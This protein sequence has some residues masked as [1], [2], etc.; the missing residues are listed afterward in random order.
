MKDCDFCYEKERFPTL[1]QENE[2]L[3]QQ[4]KNEKQLNAE[5]KK[6]LVAVEYDSNDL[7]KKRYE[8]NKQLAKRICELQSDLSKAKSMIEKMK[9]CVNCK[10]YEPGTRADNDCGQCSIMFCQCQLDKHWCEAHDEGCKYWELEEN[11]G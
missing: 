2:Q 10:Y 4:L 5:I 1:K 9:R 11:E 6:R 3:K 8:E 7:L